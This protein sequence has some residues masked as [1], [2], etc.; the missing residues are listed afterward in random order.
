MSHNGYLEFIDFHVV[1]ADLIAAPDVTEHSVFSLSAFYHILLYDKNHIRKG[2]IVI[3][4]INR[5]IICK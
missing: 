1:L 4:H 5:E 3:D 2:I